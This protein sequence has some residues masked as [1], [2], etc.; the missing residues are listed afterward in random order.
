MYLFPLQTL[1]EVK[2]Q[3]LSS[4]CLYTIIMQGMHLINRKHVDVVNKL[5]LLNTN[6]AEKISLQLHQVGNYN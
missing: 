2:A 6:Q 3:L 1:F 4:L 5:V